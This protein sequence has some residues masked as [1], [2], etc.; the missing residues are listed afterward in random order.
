[1][2]TIDIITKIQ[3]YIYPRRPRIKENFIDYDPLRAGTV[4]FTRF[5]RGVAQI[6]V[7]GV[8]EQDIEQVARAFERP[9]GDVDYVGFVASVDAVFG[10]ASV[11]KDPSVP[12]PPSGSTVPLR[13]VRPVENEDKLHHVMHRV[14]L[15]TKTRGVVFK[16]CFQDFDRA[17][18]ASLTAPR[19]SGRVSVE[20]FRRQ[21]PFSNELSEDEI[22]MLIQRYGDSDSPE[23]VNYQALHDDVTDP[24]TQVAVEELPRSDFI[25]RDQSMV[26]WTHDNISA[27]ERIQARVVERRIRPRDYFK[28]F[29][30]LKKG[31]CTVGQLRTVFS[32]M[33]INVSE[34]DLDELCKMYCRPGDQMFHYDA[35]QSKVDSV[36]V[37]KGLELDPTARTPMPCPDDTAATRKNYVTAGFTNASKCV[38]E[39]EENTCVQH[40]E[41]VE[42]KIRARVSELRL[43][44]KT[45]FKDF[46]NTRQ[47]HVTSSQFMRVLTGLNFSISHA[48]MQLLATKYCDR[49]NLRDVNYKE[50]CAVIDPECADTMLAEAQ[51]RSVFVEDSSTKYFNK[52]GEVC[53]A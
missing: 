36:F 1:M 6:G 39:V 2:D 52:K 8:T 48:D 5:V 41:F 53:P 34:Q 23:F 4:S 13:T 16:Y 50:F 25:P 19:R 29:D 7:P 14:A 31:F 33:N 38:Q 30:P 10:P 40:M 27:V 51:D 37:T 3:N 20:I 42:S 45:F 47:G 28:D 49:G 21:F 17:D 18:S 15:L 24:T 35:F 22:N 12:V 43:P 26:Q 11:Y 32:I 9:N 44:M 46:D